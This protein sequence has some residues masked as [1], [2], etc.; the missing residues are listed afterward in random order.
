[1]VRKGVGYSSIAKGAV[2]TP[3]GAILKKNK[4]GGV[5]EEVLTSSYT[6]SETS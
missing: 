1:M 6:F 2:F 5:N 3:G 4:T